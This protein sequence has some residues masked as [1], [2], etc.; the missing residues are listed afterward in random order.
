MPAA[1]GGAIIGRVGDV[2]AYVAAS[3]LIV[4]GAA[5]AAPTRAV[6]AG[7]EP[8]ARDNRLVLAMEWIAEGVAHVFTGTL[9]LVVTVVGGSGD[10][11]SAA[12]YRTAAGA[13]VVI[14]VLTALTGAR[15]P[16]LPFRI[17]PFVLG[18]AAGLLVASSLV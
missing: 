7:F 9:V 2:L 5:H 18:A 11:V 4:W 6:I 10:E 8:L 3:T 15:T 1:A 17:C 14:A 13:L 16:P 12:V